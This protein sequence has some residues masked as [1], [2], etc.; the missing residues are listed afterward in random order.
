MEK[1]ISPGDLI[2][3]ADQKEVNNPEDASL[4]I[5]A[6]VKKKRKS[7]LI[8]LEGKDGIRFVAIRLAE[9]K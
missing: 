8:Y 2:V 7:V 5:E 4:Q 3:E 6:A 1:G 9:D